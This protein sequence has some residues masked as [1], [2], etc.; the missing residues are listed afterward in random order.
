MLEKIPVHNNYIT[1]YPYMVMHSYGWVSMDILGF[2]NF[3]DPL[4]SSASTLYIHDSR[5]LRYFY[6]P[7]DGL[8]KFLYMPLG[9]LGSR[10]HKRLQSS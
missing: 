9:H 4:G 6:K 7:H 10:H 1:K 8:L 2:A 5:H 3:T